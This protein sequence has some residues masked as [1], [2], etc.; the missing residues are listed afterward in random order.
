MSQNVRQN[1]LFAA[2]DYTKIYKSFENVDFTSYDVDSIQTALINNLRINYPESFNDYIQSSEM[3]A[4]IQLLSYIASSLAFRTDLNARENILDTAERRES[5]IRL[6]R[7]INYQPKRNIPLSGIMKLTAIQTSA[8]IKDN[9]GRDLQ[10]KTIFWDDANNVDSYDQFISILDTALLSTNPFGKPYKKMNLNGIPT[11]LYQLNNQKKVEVAWP[12]TA[13]VNG[14]G[15]N[16]D[17]CNPDLDENGVLYEVHPNPENAFNILHRNDGQGLSSPNT[18]FF[19]FFK[20]GNLIKKDYKFDFAVRN[21]VVNVDVDNINE[22]DVYVQEINDQ[23]DVIQ[24]WT[25]IP[26]VNG[27]T[28]VIYNA[29]SLDNRNIYSVI[30]DTNDRVK[31]NFADGNFGNIPTGIFRTWVRPSM[32]QNISIRPEQASNL[33]ISIPY[34]SKDGQL[35]TL[36]LIFSLQYTVSN[37]SASETTAQIKTRASQVYYTQDRM[38]NNEDYN[39]FPLTRG[40]EIAKVRC[41][42]RTHAGHSRY[43]D[44]NDP[45]GYHQNLTITSDDGAL[46]KDT[47]IP[48]VDVEVDEEL[49]EEAIIT[50]VS[51]VD[52]IG[53]NELNNFFYDDYLLEYKRFKEDTYN[54]AVDLYNKYN[55]FEFTSDAQNLPP[56]HNG[57]YAFM[58]MPENEYDNKGVIY[59]T[60]P[61]AVVPSDPAYAYYDH[62]ELKQGEDDYGKFVFLS[63]GCKIK[64]VDPQNPANEKYVT[65][66]SMS[67]LDGGGTLFMFDVDVPKKWVVKEIFPRFRGTFTDLEL[68]VISD[69]IKKRNNFGLVYSIDSDAWTVTN[70]VNEDQGYELGVV[71]SDWVLYTRYDSNNKIYQFRSRGT[72]YVF[73]SFRDV[74]FFFDVEQYNYD[75]K[76]GKAK[77]D[78]I[79]ITTQNFTPQ[80]REI[81]QYN[82]NG[83][84]VNV[85]DE[86][87]SYT[88]F[89]SVGM[90]PLQS[91]LMTGDDVILD[92]LSPARVGVA[93]NNTQPAY[94]LQVNNG[95]LY[96]GGA[97][98]VAGD[99]VSI[100]YINKTP[101]MDYPVNWGILDHVYQED[102]YMDSSK[103]VVTPADTD[104]DGVPDL[105]FSFQKVVADNSIVFFENNTTYD[106]YENNRLWVSKW[107]DVRGQTEY[108]F[109]YA[110]LVESDLFISDV[111]NVQNLKDYITLL[112]VSSILDGTLSDSQI[113][114]INTVDTTVIY[115]ERFETLTRQPVLVNTQGTPILERINVD[116]QLALK[117][118]SEQL[119]AGIYDPQGVIND[120]LANPISYS[121][122][123]A[124]YILHGRSFTEN[125]QYE[126]YKQNTF[127]YKWHHYAPTDNRIDPSISNI[128]DMT[129]MT[130]SYYKD[131]LVWKNKRQGMNL[132]PK[133]PS[134]EELRLQFNE[135]NNYKMRSDQII[136]QPGK[137]KLLFGKQA[138][139]KL[140]AKFK[141]VKSPSAGITDNEIKTKVIEAI[142]IFFNIQ[143]WDFGEAFY[144]TELAAFIHRYMAKYISSVVIVPIDK[145]AR[146]GDLFQIKAEPNEL[147]LSIAS[148]DDVEIVT[149]LTETNLRV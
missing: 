8:P 22:T 43:I 104:G 98:P 72:R 106:G 25:K 134:S 144:Y 36:R 119:L 59:N 80:I 10:N 56:T 37:S 113:N 5:I 87:V 95:V 7:M 81:W 86:N 55:V 64:F 118:R 120:P 34:Y 46:Y 114:E 35:Y 109:T 137:F 54:S 93:P 135:L 16:I 110:D 45:T 145:E 146:F 23:G 142:D 130:L 21:R 28:N 30:S 61:S 78:V 123:D 117:A 147:F 73:E 63:E 71:G 84:W 3:V 143:N 139:D 105:M 39:V 24:E 111:Q 18:G 41:I 82:S 103:V 20:Q 138:D 107:I 65:V 121:V 42:N 85:Q 27:G 96:I 149:N 75:I 49:N 50:N 127:N 26:N 99:V 77:R 115:T 44:I 33:E 108:D 57:I 128:M 70:Y 91:R 13:Y 76:T 133:Q 51:L 53:N 148:I 62:N 60:S 132:Y 67:S 32:N 89:G 19:L 90:I 83:Q 47:T 66:K 100:T 122:D 1:N 129:V 136:F 141:V 11:S 116:V 126:G 6:A 12:V 58:P 102:G 112:L 88:H 14:K 74:R 40:N 31:L 69:N 4:H 92:N 124:H 9:V 101:F 125:V 15:V 94:T 52:F 38:V 140:K 17:I 2:E 97:V 131:V 68:S 29:I 48:Y 79:E